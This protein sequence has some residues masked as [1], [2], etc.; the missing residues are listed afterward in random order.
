MYKILSLII[1]TILFTS[2]GGGGGGSSGSATSS[3]VDTSIGANTQVVS[4]FENIVLGEDTSNLISIRPTE[5]KTTINTEIVGFSYENQRDVSFTINSHKPILA[6]K[7]VLFYESNKIVSTPLGNI[8]KLENKII[9]TVFDNLGGLNITHTLANHIT[10][11]WLVIPFYGIKK[12][13]PIINNS[14]N[15]KINN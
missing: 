7:Q 3:T 4:S 11:V 2:C 8:E 9:A 13:I 6:S 1:I 15:L 5:T 12:Q 10:S 14:I